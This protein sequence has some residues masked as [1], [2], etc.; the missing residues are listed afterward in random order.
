MRVKNFRRLLGSQNPGMVYGR[1]PQFFTGRQ[2]GDLRHLLSPGAG[3]RPL[4]IDGL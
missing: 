1:N 3:Q 2:P 4:W